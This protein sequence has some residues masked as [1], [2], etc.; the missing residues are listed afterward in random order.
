MS[1]RNATIGTITI[2]TPS[3]DAATSNINNKLLPPPV[4]MIA[5]TNASS[6][7]PFVNLVDGLS[8][9]G[10][11]VQFPLDSRVRL[12]PQCYTDLHTDPPL[13]LAAYYPSNSVRILKSVYVL[14]FLRLLSSGA[15]IFAVSACFAIL[16]FVISFASFVYLAA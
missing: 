9:F 8:D 14:G 1:C 16:F 11:L 4:G 6:P 2:V 15:I 12:P 7:L 13:R 3:R 10:V 5:K